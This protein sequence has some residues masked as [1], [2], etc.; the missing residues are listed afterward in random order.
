MIPGSDVLADGV[1]GSLSTSPSPEPAGRDNANSDKSASV[2][3]VVHLV[4]GDDVT[5]G[6]GSDEGSTEGVGGE[7]EAR[8]GEGARER[9]VG[10]GAGAGVDVELVA[11]L[12]PL[13]AAAQRASTF[14]L[15]VRLS[16]F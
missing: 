13:S 14:L 5:G 4:P 7:G 3:S 12:D 6:S 2:R 9:G 15:L 16:Y 1:A 11:V 8:S 10:G